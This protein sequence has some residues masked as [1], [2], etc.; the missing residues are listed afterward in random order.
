[1]SERVRTTTELP[2]DA[3]LVWEA[4]TSPDGVE[5]WLGEGS[6]LEPREGTDLDVADVET[7][8]RR[9]GRVDEVDPGRR[10]GFVWWPDGDD[11]SA[12]HRVDV[13]LTPH[14]GGTTLTVTETPLSALACLAAPTSAEAWTWRSAAM[15]LALLAPR[16]A[17]AGAV[18]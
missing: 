18:V 12:G 3:D 1:M 11:P 13:V 4:L 10:L 7:G 5:S 17:C 15:E 8:V 9:V 6:R 14:G 2:A 16:L